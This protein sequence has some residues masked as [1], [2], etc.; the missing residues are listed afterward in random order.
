MFMTLV[1]NSQ[2]TT[3]VTKNVVV[4]SAIGTKRAAL[5]AF[6]IYPDRLWNNDNTDLIDV[7]GVG[8]FSER[9]LSVRV[10]HRRIT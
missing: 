6:N 10:R 8:A 5:Y 3:P 4:T 9:T 2:S 7:P 1:E